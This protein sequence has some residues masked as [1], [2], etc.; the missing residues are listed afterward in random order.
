VRLNA[1][2]TLSLDEAEQALDAL[3]GALC[4]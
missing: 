2:L 4:R 1:P 3:T